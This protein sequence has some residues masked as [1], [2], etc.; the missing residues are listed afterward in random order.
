MPR[1]PQ[2]ETERLKREISVQGLAEARGTALQ[3]LFTHLRGL[4]SPH[5][6]IRSCF[7]GSNL[8]RPFLGV[9]KRFFSNVEECH[10][11]SFV[12]FTSDS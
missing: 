2:E 10:C 8:P 9:K 3:S 4:P 5:D 12:F 7:F 1:V 6:L 11:H